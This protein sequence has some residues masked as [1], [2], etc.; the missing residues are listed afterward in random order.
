MM[1]VRMDESNLCRFKADMQ[2]AFQMG[3]VEGGL[4]VGDGA[5]LPEGDVDESLNK[6][7]STAYMAMMGGEMVGGAVVNIDAE[8]S[9]GHLDFLYVKYGIQGRGIGKSIWFGIE[10]M[11][12]EIDVW[13]TCTPYFDMRN[14]HFYINVCGFHAV[15]FFN[16]HHPDP[17][18]PDDIFCREGQGMFVFR[19]I[20]GRGHPAVRHEVC[21]H[22]GTKRS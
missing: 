9:V 14:I 16:S 8:D 22:A 17:D 1:S 2:E 13:E 5:I 12:P 11:Y 7:N 4:D 10:G 3:A 6:D 20:V 18:S 21:G 19:K 15:E